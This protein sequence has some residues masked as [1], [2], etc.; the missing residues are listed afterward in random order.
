[1]KRIGKEMSVFL[2]ANILLP[3]EKNLEKWSVIACDQFTSQPEYWKLVR[4]YVGSVPSALH[5]ILPE[6]ELNQNDLQD[7]VKLQENSNTELE[8]S[9]DKGELKNRIKTINSYMEQYIENDIFDVYKN[10]YIYVERTLQNGTIRKGVVGM[11]DLEQY[12][13]ERDTS[14]YIRPTEQTVIERIPP[15]V[16]VRQNAKLELSH[17]L[18]FCNDKEQTLLEFLEQNK[19]HLQKAYDLELMMDGGSLKGW[20]VQGEIATIFNEKI[21]QYEQKIKE[22]YNNQEPMLYAVGDGNHSLATAKACYE[23]LKKQYPQKD[24]SNHPARYAMVELE[25]ICDKVQ[26]FEP[27]HRVITNVDVLHLLQEMKQK[28]GICEESKNVK[29]VPVTYYCGEE[30]GVFYLKEN[31][32]EILLETIQNF[33]DNYLKENQGEIDYIHGKDI[34]KQL[35]KQENTIGFV[36]STIDKTQLFSEIIKKG[37]LPRKTFSMGHAKEK[38]YYMETRQIQ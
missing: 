13:Y 26:Q 5:L 27:I 6:A 24:F 7:S 31:N 20:L 15:R 14:S 30:E 21:Q 1:M 37:V 38:R 23:Q 29:A 28:I 36:L 17:I 8:G 16:L 10:C 35:S 22:E 9:K 3:T 18:L 19:N 33:L 4:E 12:D 2:P 32:S 34:L 11:V 25:N